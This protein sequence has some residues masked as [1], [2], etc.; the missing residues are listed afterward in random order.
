MATRAASFALYILL[1]TL[2]SRVAEA[3]GLAG[4]PVDAS[5]T[6]YCGRTFIPSP[7]SGTCDDT[8]CWG[9]AMTNILGHPRSL[10]WVALAKR[11]LLVFVRWIVS[12]TTS[13][14]LPV[15]YADGAC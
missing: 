12:E 15:P 7:G 4:H 9:S 6:P 3:G 5:D 2:C 14:Y 1:L 10:M 8:K 13:A 11:Q